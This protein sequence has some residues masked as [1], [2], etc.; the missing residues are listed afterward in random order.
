MQ[1]LVE[2]VLEAVFRGLIEGIVRG[3]VEV[4][5]E[6]VCYWVG[7]GILRLLSS[8]AYPPRRPSD[9]QVMVSQ[10][11]GLCGIIVAIV[12]VVWASG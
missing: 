11:T 2:D 1:M 7:K 10:L 12:V 3:V 5:F 9:L 8:G 4:V 6:G